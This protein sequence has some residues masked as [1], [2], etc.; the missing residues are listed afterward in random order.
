MFNEA[1]QF[2]NVDRFLHIG[3]EKGHFAWVTTSRNVVFLEQPHNG[4]DGVAERTR[5]DQNSEEPQQ[6]KLQE[7]QDPT[8]RLG[9]F[10]DGHDHV[11]AAAWMM[12]A[13]TTDI[14]GDVGTEPAEQYGLQ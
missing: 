10:A 13:Y 11:A 12:D 7:P 8:V 6:E 9:P 2:L 4:G 5:E 3:L 14:D 1:L